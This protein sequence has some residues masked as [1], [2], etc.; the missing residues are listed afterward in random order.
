MSRATTHELT[1]RR[2]ER[3]GVW[4]DQMAAIR[5]GW[6]TMTLGDM[7]EVIAGQSLEDSLRGSL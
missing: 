3:G 4:E 1:R 2:G 5:N 7:A 6:K